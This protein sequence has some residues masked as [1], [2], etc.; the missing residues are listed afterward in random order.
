M[1]LQGYSGTTLKRRN[2]ET[3]PNRLIARQSYAH[4]RNT[5][6]VR[7]ATPV[8]DS[9]VLDVCHPSA[10]VVAEAPGVLEPRPPAPVTLDLAGPWGSEAPLGEQ[11]DELSHDSPPGRPSG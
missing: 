2:S 3:G 11:V 6:Q 4:R 8:V 10:A 5:A 1:P 7:A 9:D